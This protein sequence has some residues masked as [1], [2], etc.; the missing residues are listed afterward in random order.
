MQ[1]TG[2]QGVSPTLPMR[3]RRKVILRMS[4]AL[5]LNLTAQGI[6]GVSISPRVLSVA[7]TQ[8]GKRVI[9]RQMV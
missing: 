5:I 9:D 1:P 3:R 7:H 2:I 4:P 6:E 8:R